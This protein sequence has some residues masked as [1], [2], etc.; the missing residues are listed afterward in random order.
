MNYSL[1]CTKGGRGGQ[2]KER[3]R[4][5]EQDREIKR[6][7]KASRKLTGQEWKRF[8]VISEGKLIMENLA[9]LH[10]LESEVGGGGV[11]TRQAP[12][13]QSEIFS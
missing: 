1:A 5:G 4:E 11:K 13:C 12:R 2:K 3:E 7:G 10:S 8:I 9:G 6:E